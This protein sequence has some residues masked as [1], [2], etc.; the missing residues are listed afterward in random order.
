M[1]DVYDRRTSKP[2][3]DILKEHFTREGRIQ[4]EVV[5]LYAQCFEAFAIRT[6][7]SDYSRHLHFIGILYRCII[8]QVV[9]NKALRIRK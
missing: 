9:K 7:N 3:S 8:S 4:E 2:R 5:I 6:V 1:E